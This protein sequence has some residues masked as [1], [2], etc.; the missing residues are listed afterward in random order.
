MH[1]V[2]QQPLADLLPERDGKQP[3][4]HRVLAVGGVIVLLIVGIL[5][6][7]FPIVPGFPFLIAAMLVLPIV[8]PGLRK[9]INAWDRRQR[10]SRRVKLR[11]MIS[12]VPIVRR[13]A[14]VSGA[15][16]VARAA[17]DP[18]RAPRRGHA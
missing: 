5:G 6:S 10:P 15:A 17:A 4:W 7:I 1:D 16:S 14:N 18:E 8:F 9:R 13:Q 2:R 12:K 11:R 3:L